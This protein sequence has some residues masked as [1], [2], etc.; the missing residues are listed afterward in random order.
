MLSARSAAK[1]L[2]CAQDYVSKL[3]REGKLRGTQIEGAWFV[4]EASIHEFEVSRSLAKNQR[5]DELARQ[6]REENAAYR[7]QQGIVPVAQ[8][9][10][11]STP[12]PSIEKFFSSLAK[13]GTRNIALALGS[14]LLFAAV[15]FAGGV[16]SS[17]KSSELAASLAQ[18]ESPFFGA[19]P[20]SIGSPTATSQSIA[21]NFFENLFS[22]FFGGKTQA[23]YAV[24]PVINTPSPATLPNNSSQAVA[25][26]SAPKQIVQNTY[27]VIEHTTTVEHVVSGVTEEML[28]SQLSEL[29]NTLRSEFYAQINGITT[30]TTPGYAAGG[31]TNNVA[32]SQIIDKLDGVRITNATIFGS[33]IDGY[34]PTTG[35]TLTG[36][37][38]VT[39]ATSTLSG[40]AISGLDCSGFGNSGKLTTDASGNIVCADDSSG[41]GSGSPGGANTQ[42]Q[43]NDSGNFGGNAAFTFN[44]VA[45]RAT[46]T[47]ASTTGFTSS[48]AST[49]NLF[50]G[51]LT[52]GTSNGLLFGTNGSIGTIATNT[53]G[54]LASSSISATGPLAYNVATGVFSITQSSATTD[55]YLAASDFISFN[56]RLSTTTLG[57]FDKGF[58]FSTTSADY[59]KTQNDFFSTTS[60][61][62]FVNSSTTIPHGSGAAYGD[63]FIWNGSRWIPTATST[64][65]ITSS[66]SGSVFGQAWEVSGNYLAPTSTIGIIVSASSTFNGQLTVVGTSTL[67]IASTTKFYGAGLT[68]CQGG[69]VLT[70]SGGLF[71]CVADQTSTGQLNPFTFSTNYGVLTAATTSPISATGGIFA[72]STSHF[73]NA[74]FTNATTTNLSIGTLTGS[75]QAVNGVVSA[76]SSLSVVYGGTGVTSAP[77]YGQILV[78]NA[79]GGY[80]LTATSSL[81]ITSLGSLSGTYPIQYN[82][83]TGVFSLAFG[84]TTANTWSALQTFSAGFLASAS[85][86]V[87]GNFTVVGTTTT[88]NLLV[89][90]LNGPLQANGGV[91]SATSSIGV[92]YG[93][94]GLT[95][96]PA[97][98]NLLVGNSSGGYTLT[99]TSSLGFL[100]SNDR[101]WQITNGYLT[102][103][104]TLGILVAASSTIGNGSAGGGLTVSGDATTTGLL[105][106][107][108]TGTSTI[109]S[110]LAMTGNIVPSVNNVYSLGDFSHAWKEVFIGPGSLYVNGQEVV[111][112]DGSNNVVVSSSI[113]QNLVLQTTGSANIELNPSGTGQLLIKNTV[114]VTAGKSITTSDLSALSIPNG[115]AAGN[116]IVSGNAITATNLNGGISLTPAG[117]GGTYVT[118]GNFGIGTTTPA[119]TL[120]VNGSGYITAGLGVGVLNTTPGTLQ[121]S[122]TTTVGGGLFVSGSTTLATSLTGPLQAVNG[123]ISATT[124]LSQLYGGTGITSY[125]SGDIL[126]ANGAGKLTVLPVGNSGQ[127]LKVTAGLLPAW[128]ADQTTGGGGA[129]AWATTT[130]S[131]AIYPANTSYVVLVGNSA[132]TTANSILEVIGKS[133]FSTTV[134]IGTTS[135]SALLSVQGNALF[136]GNLSVANVTAT[137]TVTTGNL[138][139]GSLNGLLYGTNG[140][141][142]TIATNTLGLLGSSSISATAPLSYNVSTGVFSITQSS[143]TTD[144]YLSSTDWNSFNARLSTTSLA[145]FD[146]GYFFSTTS[147]SYFL[148]QQNI[149]GFSTTS[150]DYWKTQNNF[151]STTSA[152]YFVNSSTTIVKAPAAPSYGQLLL[153]NSAGGYDLVATSSLGI[154]S[155]GSL[156]GTYP[157]QYNSSTGVFSLAFGTTTA[158]TWSALQ[159]FSAGFLASASSTINGG[160]T[161]VGTATSTNVAIT[162]VTSTLLKTNSLGQIT[163]AVLG[164]DYQNFGYLFP[165]NATT[166]QIAFNGGLTT[167]GFLSTASSTINSNLI[168]TGNST[169]T[170]ATTSALA[171]SNIASGNIVKTTTGGALVAA[172]AGQ[173]YATPSQV[174]AAFPFIVTAYGVST[175]TTVGFTSGLLSTASSTFT[176]TL[177]LSSL[178]S[179]GLAVNASGQV[180]AAPTTTFSNGLAYSGGNVINTIGYSFLNNATSTTL[181]FNGGLL[182]VGSTTL[183]GNAT[184]T[185]SFYA[186]IASSTNLYGAGLASCT[187]GNVLTWVNG[188]FGCAVDQTSTGKIDPFIFSTNFGVTAAATSSP[189]WAQ[190]GLFASSTTY[191]TNATTSSFAITSLASAVLKV[192]SSGSVVAAT[193]GTDFEN[194]LT[195]NAPLTRSVNAISITQSGLAA[196][197]YLSSA[198]F[199]SFNNKISSTSLS[200]AS[201]ISYNSST[202]VISTQAGTFGGN[203]SSVYTFPGDVNITGN[204][205]STNATSTNL[206]VAAT[207]R[208]AGL[209]ACSSSADKLL[210]NASLGQFSCGTDVGSGGSNEINWTFFN[211]SGVRVSTSSNQ[212]L[213][214]FTSTSSLSKL[215]VVGGATFDNATTTGGLSVGGIGSF[216]GNVGLGTT[217]PSQ[218]LTIAGGN[219]LQVASGNPTIASSTY[220]GASSQAFSVYVAGRYAYVAAGPSGL[221]I[222]D[223]TNPASSTVVGTYAGISNAQAVVVSGKYA[224]VGDSTNGLVVI[225]V[226]KPS[227]PSLVSSIAAGN[228][229]N[230]AFSGRYVIVPDFDTGAVNVVDIANPA[231]P[232]IVGTVTTG[233][234]PTSI[235]ISGSYVYIGDVTDGTVAVVNISNPARPTIASTYS[236]L[237]SPAGVYVSGSYAY[238]ADSSSGLYILNIANP[239]ALT[240]VSSLTGVGYYS[241]KVAGDYVYAANPSGSMAVID[242]R[243]ATKPALIGSISTGG[244]P[245]SVFVSGKYAYVA[246]NSTTLKA[247]DVNGAT[248]PAA[249]IGALES[250]VINVADNLTVGGDG[251]FGGG[252]NIGLS[253]IF[254]R[255]G[256]AVL[257]TTTLTDLIARTSTTTNATTTNSFATTASSTSLF[258]TSAQFRNATTTSLYIGSLTGPLQ[259]ING[260]VS[261]S[262]SLSVFYGGTG[263]TTLGGILKGNGTGSIVS[264]VAGTDYA[265]PAQI[266]SAYPFQGAG[267]STSTTVGFT[268][269]LLSTASSTFTSSLTLSSLTSGGLAVS[270]TGL[271]YKAATTTFSSGLTYSGGNVTLD[272]MFPSNATNTLIAFNG[273][274]TT[275]G[276]LSTASSTI[277]S[278]LIITGNSTTTNATTSALAVSNIASGNIVKTTTGGAL[279]AA[280]SGT[281]YATPAQ[282]A[283]AY[284][285]QGAGNST[286]TTVGF[287]GGLLSTASSTF[288]SSLTLSSLTSGGLAVSSTGLLYKA[289]TTTFSSGL[290]YSGGN[291]TL[292]WM[293]PSNATTTQIAFNGG[294]T[295]SGATTTNLAVTAS[296]TIG[297]T[298]NVGTAINAN[299][300][301]T[302]AGNTTLAGATSTAFAVG[303]IASGNIV[304]TTTGGALIAAISGTDY[305]TPAQIAAAYPFQVTGN[306]TTTLTQFNGG[307]TAYASSTIGN[308]TATG[309]LTVSGNA[310]TT[311]TAYFAGNVGIGT[312]SPATALDVRGRSTLHSLSQ[313]YVTL[314]LVGSSIDNNWGPRVEFGPDNGTT[315]NKAFMETST[316]G[317]WVGS[318]SNIPL[319]FD[320]NNT[321]KVRIDGSGNLGIGTTSPFAKLSVAGDAYIGGNLTA[322][323][324]LAVTGQTTLTTVT[325][326]TATTT[327]LAVTGVTSSLLKTNSLGQITAAV[328]GTDYQNFGYLFPSNATNTLIAFNGGLTTAGFLST[329]SSTI[330]SN[331]IITG[332]STTTNATSSAFAISNIS[333]GNLL[334]TTTGG[335]VIAAI[336]GTDYATPAQ[337]AAAYPF[338]VTGNATSTLTQFNGGLTAFASS[339][340]GNGTAAGGLTVN[341]TA[342]STNVV[343][344]AVTSTLLKTN[345]LGQITAA[346]LGTD[347]QNFGYLF[348]SNATTTQIA[349]NGGLTASGA[350]TTNLAVT[351]SSTIGTTLNVGTAINAN[352]TL[353]VAGNTTL[354]GATSTAFAVGNIASGNI[355]KTTT[356]GALIAAISGTDYATPAQIAAAYPFQGAGNSTSTTVGFTGGLLSTASS[357]FTSSLTLSSLTS[358]GLA[359]SSTG[360]LYKAATTTYSCSTGIACS[361]S[362]GVATFTNTY[363]YPFAGANN[364]TSTL[365]QFNGG[366][367]AFASSTIGNGTAA[368]G[369][370]VNGTA[371]ST[372]V[373]VTAVTS[374]LLK[375]NSLGQIT[376]AVL[377]TDY[378]NFAFPFSSNTN[379]GALTNS[380]STPIWFVAGL[381]A[382][383]TAQLAAANV[384][385]NLGVGTTSPN[386]NL[387]IQKNY[388]TTNT[389]LFSIASSTNSY[390]TTSATFFS[391]NNLGSTTLYQIPSSVLKT[392]SNGTIIAAISGTDY[393]TPAQIAAA[394]PFQGA[395]NSTSTTVGF[396]G[397]LLSTASSTF[398]SS[399][400]LS[401]LTS[402][403]L[404][405]SSTGLVYKAATTT[406]SSGLT[407]SGGNVTL[408]WMFPSN[409]TNTLIAFNGGLT[410]AGFLS[411]ASSTINSNLII[412]GNSTTTNATSSAFAISNISSGNLLKTTTGGAVIAAI[413][414]TDYA[415]PAQIAAAYPFQV[416][417]N[418]TSTLTQ[419][420]GGLTAFASSTIGN[421]TAAGGLTVNGTATSTNVVVTAVTSTLLKTNS[422]GQIT[423]AVLGTDYQN[424]G[425]LFPSNATTTQIAF[426][427]GLTASG[428]TTTNLAVTASSTIGTTLNVGT[429][430]NANGTLTVAGNTTL[431][432]A[433]STAFA[434]GNIA[435]GNIVKTTTGGALIAAISGTDYATPAQIAAA[436]PFQGAGN[437]TST[438]VGFTGGLLSTASST[439]TSSLTLSSL[440]SG[441]LAVSSTGL[442]Y[443]AATTTYSC[444]TGIACSYSGGVATFTNTYGYPFAG[445]NN[446]T[447]TLTQFNGGL[448]AFASSTIGNGTAAGGLTVNGTATSTNVVVTAVTSTLLKTNSLGQITAAVLGTDYQNFAF[449]FSSNTN[450][451]AL[452]NSTSTPIWFVA[453][454]QASSTAQLAAANVYGNLGVGTTSPNINL[455]IQKNYGTTNTTLFSIA[456][457]TNSYGTTSATFFS[458][459]N[460]GST[461]LYQIPSSVLKTDSNGTIIAA[462]SGTDYATPAQIAAAYPFQVTGNATSTL[463]QF[464]GGLTAFASSTIGNGTA[465]GGLTVNGTATSTNVVVTAVTSTLLKTNSLGQITAAVLGTDYQNF[466]YL[467]PSNATTTQIAFN[468]GLTASGATT[469]NLAVTA[470]STIGTTL[471]VGTAIN[472]NG[473]LTVAGNTTLAGATSTAFAVGNIASGNIVKTTTGGALIAAIS[474]T[475]YAT[476]AQ[477]AAAYPFQVTGNATTTLTQFN[478]GLTAYASSTIG[479]G[480]QGSGLTISGGA[481]T[482][483]NA[484]FAGSVGVGTSSPFALFSINPTATNGSAPVFAIGSSSATL[485]SVSNTGQASTTK[486]IGAGLTTC[487]SGNVLTWSA[488][489]FGCAADATTAGIN[490]FTWTTNFGAITAATSSILWAQNGI[491]ASSTS[492][493][494]DLSIYGSLSFAQAATTTIVNNNPFAFTIATSSTGSPLFRIDTTSGSEQVTLGST[495]GDVVI[496]DV[497][498]ATNLIFEENSTIKGQGTGR[499][500][501]FGANSDKINFGVNIGIGTTSPYAMLSLLATSTNGVNSPT[502]LF[503]IASTTGGTATSTLFTVSN[504]GSTTLFRI[505]SSVLKTDSN[506][507]IIAAISGTDYA[508]PAQIASAYPF[509]VTGNATS[510]LTQFNGGLT[511][512]A[513]STIGAGGQGSG[514]TISGGATTTGNAN[515]TG[516]LGVGTTTPFALVAINPTA[517]NGSAPVF[518]IGSSSA[519]LFSVDNVGQASTTKFIGAGLTTCNSGNVLTW[520]SGLFGCAADA[521]SAG[522]NP[523]TWTTNFGVTAAATTSPI[524]AQNGIFASSTSNLSYTNIDGL[525][526][527]A[528]SSTS[529]IITFAGRSFVVASTTSRNTALGVDAGKALSSSSGGSNTFLGY[530]AGFQVSSGKRNIAIG[531]LAL[532][533]VST[534]DDNIAIGYQA[535]F[536]V[537]TGARG[538]ILIGAQISTGGGNHIQTGINNLGLGNDTWFPSSVASNQINIGN[539]LYGTM[540]AT[541]TNFV[542]PTTG[543]LGV[544][545]TSPYAL[546]S[547]HANNGSTNLT[548]FA[549]GSSTASATSTL[550]SVSNT[551]ST[552][553][554]QIPSSVLKTDSNGTIIAAIS[555]TDYATPAQIASAY[556]F[557]VTGNAT[558][559]LTQFNGGLTAYAS[560]TIGAGGQGSGLTI[561]GGATTT[562]NANFTGKLGVGTT[563][564]FALV[565]INPTA[566][567]GSAP[568]FAIGS[569]SATLFS[570]DNV[571]QASTTK[572]IGAGLTTCN[573]GNVLTWAS[574]LF[575]CAADQTGAGGGTFPFTPGTFGATAVNATS[576]A[577]QL[578]GGLYA[579]STVR[580]G[581][582]GI[583]PF[584]FDGA[585]GKLALGTT[586]TYSLLSVWG[587]TANTGARL[588]EVTNSASTTMFSVDDTGSATLGTTGGTGDAKIQFASDSNAWT[589]GYAS[590]DKSFRIASSTSLSANVL[591]TLTKSG[592]FGLS[593][594]SPFAKLSIDNP[595]SSTNTTLFNISSTTN[596]GGVFSTSTL[597]SVSNTGL[598]TIGDSGATGDANFQF[599]SDSNAWSM[600]YA[601][602]DKSFRIASSTDLASNVAFMISKGGYIGLASST[603]STL[604]GLNIGTSTLLGAGTASN[605]T[606]NIG[607]VAY[608][609]SA[610]TTIQNV[611][612]GF[613]IATSTTAGNGP[614]LS[615]SGTGATSTISFFG[616]TTTGLAATGGVGVPVASRNML[617]IGNGKTQANISIVNGGICVDNDGWCTASTTG[618]IT[619]RSSFLTTGADVAEMYPAAETM[620]QGEIAAT[621]NGQIVGKANAASRTRVIGI[622]SSKPSLT[623]GDATNEGDTFDG[624]VPIALVGRVPVKVSL[625]N[626]PINPGDRITL[627]SVPGVGMKAAA[628][629]TSVG[630]ALEMYNQNSTSTMVLAFVNLESG[631]DMA[632]LAQ[633]FASSTATTSEAALVAG[634]F[635]STTQMIKDAIHTALTSIANIAQI[636]VRELGVAV[637]ASFGIFDHLITQ[638]IVTGDITAEKVNAKTLCLD[639][640]CITKTQLQNI[641]NGTSSGGA[642]SSSGGSG[643]GGGTGSSTP[644]TEA[645]VI[646]LNGNNPATI[647]VGSTYTDLGATVTDNVDQNLDFTVSLDGGA[648]TS[649]D[650]LVIDTSATSTHSILFSATDAAGNTGTATRTVNVIQP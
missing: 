76:T 417:G 105:H 549:V 368:G 556:P 260:Q 601:T 405:V 18:V 394:Y 41:S 334:K 302:V 48:Y 112:T 207:V 270:S 107:S 285:F 317:F 616:A 335:A 496:G 568:V 574:G 89:G 10:A 382:S 228:A 109:L 584:I 134:G 139:I 229:L 589:L 378:Q 515:F 493:F 33:T 178:T 552:T 37:L 199:T 4:E 521:T 161:V 254:S 526:L 153:G 595:A 446:S 542:Y 498:A 555:G 12:A 538:N 61:N 175:S 255:G 398:T 188:L 219:I 55:G 329:A 599:A 377:G 71:G 506:G 454:L 266:A 614:V 495:G 277:N 174:G 289:A 278:N 575:G 485:F 472:A 220:L 110:N 541:T 550:F 165:S 303:N 337:I 478:G 292:D 237:G 482:T 593:T 477:I 202:G 21:G 63:V 51:S 221:K 325:A 416:T 162:A 321:E 77:T 374:T 453:G 271:V 363:G 281:D 195:F 461:T 182:S 315:A 546:L 246:T 608:S 625:E 262:S 501:T 372:N 274:L 146:K 385:G 291:V 259:A 206:Y 265:T 245:R 205:T 537:I 596:I 125:T 630:I 615:I 119:T 284:P 375:T 624:Q 438:T 367:T 456:S 201:V 444:S 6:R 31:T 449:P 590:T 508:T 215:E 104:S 582:T 26:S 580:F 439:F 355:V 194:P 43:F 470:S 390:G 290:T 118:T 597:F 366:L 286:S 343:V 224:Y 558:S 93:G 143:A 263:S 208:G 9:D 95:S 193:P 633:A 468:G 159:T 397:G 559:T 227:A 242:V 460:L 353:T 602:A 90:S 352:G 517:T 160:L 152:N 339:T 504:I 392:D 534:G 279:I 543:A 276:F 448:T 328:L 386:I 620:I 154:T 34:L 23:Q 567:N 186:N 413:S 269:G 69:N 236:G 400:T 457:S 357:T 173:D 117:S 126:Y 425:Y 350:T 106:V 458:V 623:I 426:N 415:T 190:A 459:N 67:G 395:G 123:L 78:G 492:R 177:T 418:A 216:V 288:T 371:T 388:G 340:I 275:A 232:S 283:A 387:A 640:L 563:T 443:K 218:K 436:Y 53:L 82:S 52:L 551:G 628:F 180:Y 301:L 164:T 92:L 272:W 140:S 7:K 604:F 544:A 523:F 313:N 28:T 384:Y 490:P 179:S 581:N 642:G 450:F 570:V 300:T 533:S 166:T 233:S 135:P 150:A 210:W 571:G 480:G 17:Q 557:Q 129:G 579:S 607:T 142:G 627:S 434:V 244:Q 127:V 560:S 91:V 524:W 312:S 345:S 529:T 299:G 586:T 251:Y 610:T 433:T 225:D 469:T 578:T 20:M 64:L 467:F 192:N 547:V 70:W 330:N 144:G 572:F 309:G 198:D 241:L 280:I 500:L 176:S 528:T 13:S 427:G 441:G 626:G 399:L 189:I 613:S 155:L 594:T 148:S 130:D 196:N 200:G 617:I 230:L 354:A 409:A 234:S 293:F 540:P 187:G 445:A 598:T 248:L 539:L 621:V 167:A 32:L 487:N 116:I 294:L 424:F 56:S 49:T 471:N 35:G 86:T 406:F 429:A 577:L 637:H 29:S 569:S 646:S 183:N 402:G 240:E 124:S 359:V 307:L 514:L 239:S 512:Y 518:A 298:L 370:T 147:A 102:P 268:G 74:D 138:S 137:G 513:S 27:P 171:V 306:A 145:L 491:F 156:S 336:S 80:T 287:T 365:T 591:F 338:Q 525:A 629:D 442:L 632:T 72:S 238:V 452:T 592:N 576:T 603:P 258:S 414:G 341:G 404:A 432:G 380:T 600:G 114:N 3:C 22:Y 494:V 185:G 532:P 422:L 497:G 573:S 421:G 440:T 252:L 502:T 324:T 351:A 96:A 66:G 519:T 304:K 407:Y 531:E 45:G 243:D 209:S 364:S 520:A 211:G 323:G 344:T 295:A 644:D 305:A 87:N 267:N 362:G 484:Y 40:L 214:G 505:P 65:G 111:H 411:T 141:V 509:Q 606:L 419:F 391:V 247:I 396:T 231:S 121:T 297:T 16:A 431:A 583:S 331:L 389:T 348:P 184:T 30:P 320:T 132:T 191:L 356:G 618:R 622:V 273:G 113:N 39:G 81:G 85:S 609:N 507:T 428:A 308:G 100:G 322:T 381:Q 94:T 249:R 235:A 264:A 19:H 479:A 122:A 553:L 488:G 83:L 79:S 68:S 36:A 473:T 349:F 168:I 261:A 587:S 423:A 133:Y 169:T 522:V 157:I 611:A 510:T 62:Y 42:V 223:I 566:T 222:L 319:I 360:L 131:L 650:Q 641:L 489:L 635:A 554:F 634:S 383:S 197:G 451:G 172:V 648:A 342:T 649:I 213:I 645:P 326:T 503:A 84:T 379:F 548:L 44:K 181:T 536:N 447:S 376:A 1:L 562:G 318:I 203:S 332:N 101:N 212:V 128:G 481:T 226:S 136:S 639:D 60:A 25:T 75:L 108:G 54:L 619:A 24:A 401:S 465:A 545:S 103:T 565:A 250:S 47:F 98:G 120:S 476:P 296:S 14:I 410:T 59:W 170:N 149:S 527:N 204:S 369:L 256:L 346:V 50:A 403:G 97:Y 430:I 58:F 11:F 393:A 46:I 99:S 499:T 257:G 612:N 316:N 636:G 163:A 361:Y 464:N 435:S 2:S 530:S 535:G 88:S 463:T 8:D 647:D 511:A 314:N 115:V 412:T 486:F 310:T 57:L 5:A 347:Y 462:I 253:G 475:D 516:K 437:S 217:S 483:G 564:P 151:F 15:A 588:F 327:N 158:N 466:G 358:G 38:T 282:I 420:N 643:S 408:D 605:L 561:S 585:T 474:G 631:K 73:T 373:V 638:T 455:A 311:G 333:S